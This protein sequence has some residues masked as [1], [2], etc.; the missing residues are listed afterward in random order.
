MASPVF[1]GTYR[2]NPTYVERKARRVRKV[3]AHRPSVSLWS[4]SSGQDEDKPQVN[5][6]D[7]TV[8]SI[9]SFLILEIAAAGFRPL[10]H[11]FA[12]FMIVWQR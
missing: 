3:I 9:I 5:D 2:Y 4:S 7:Q 12:Q 11:V 1:R 6:K 10:G 8:R